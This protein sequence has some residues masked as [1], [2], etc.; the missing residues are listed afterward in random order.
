MASEKT[1]EAYK[2]FKPRKGDRVTCV[3]GP[4]GVVSSIEGSLC[5]TLYDGD[6]RALPFIWLHED[7][8]N[9]LHDWPGKCGG[10]V[11]PCPG[12]SIKAG[13]QQ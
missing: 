7:G 9:A 3:D 8:L 2:A 6:E 11:A 1:I 13:A 4:S 10:K 5:W 12:I